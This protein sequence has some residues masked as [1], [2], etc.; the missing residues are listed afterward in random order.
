MNPDW[1]EQAIGEASAALT[2]EE[3][4]AKLEKLVDAMQESMVPLMMSLGHVIAGCQKLNA[5]VHALDGKG[6]A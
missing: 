2:T 6:P 1:I 3:R 4:I 5:R